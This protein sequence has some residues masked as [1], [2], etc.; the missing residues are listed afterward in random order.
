VDDN[1]LRSTSGRPQLLV[2]SGARCQLR[3][4]TPQEPHCLPKPVC[5]VCPVFKRHDC[6]VHTVDVALNVTTCIGQIDFAEQLVLIT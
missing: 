3:L 2:A 6:A 1:S 5:I 4:G